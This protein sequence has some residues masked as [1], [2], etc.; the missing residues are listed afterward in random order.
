MNAPDLSAAVWRK[1]SYS[2]GQ[3]GQCVEVA[4][5]L[6][7]LVAVRDSK[8]PAQAAL[9]FSPSAWRAF[10]ARS[11]ARNAFILGGDPGPR[12]LD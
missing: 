11:T 7:G 10:L 6:P 9:A 1:S 2:N 5:P 3:G 8:N 4:C 12:C